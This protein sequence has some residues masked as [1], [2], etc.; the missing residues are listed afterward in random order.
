MSDLLSSN[1]P[2]RAVLRDAAQES[3]AQ[4]DTAR[5][6]DIVA[7][8]VAGNAH[9]QSKVDIKPIGTWIGIAAAIAVVVIGIKYLPEG[10]GRRGRG[11]GV[12]GA[13]IYVTHPAQRATVT[14]GDGTT[15][16]LAP[17]TTLRIA[18]RTVDITG[19][20]LFT[21]AS[22]RNVP[23]TVTTDGAAV[24]VLGTTFSVRK[25]PEEKTAR[26]VVAEGKVAVNNAV[27]TTGEIAVAINGATPR[28]TRGDVSMLLSWAQGRLAFQAAPADEVFAELSRW[29]GVQIRASEEIMR[30]RITV[31]FAAESQSQAVAFLATFLNATAEYR[32]STIFLTRSSK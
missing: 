21:V 23:F 11:T 15:A 4:F 12:A 30:E 32:G 5:A 26:V 17:S 24:R 18:G 29:Y 6:R 22:S 13:R 8:K 9:R 27:V 31:E 20:A 2:L 1:D 14:L 28:V 10:E 25:Y 7:A 3:I 19:Q 16:I